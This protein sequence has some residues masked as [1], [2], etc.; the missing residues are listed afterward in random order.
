MKIGFK[1]KRHPLS[2][3]QGGNTLIELMA[4]VL[5]VTISV[6]ALYEMIV[7]GNTMLTY[8][9]HKRIALEKAQ[10]HMELMHYYAVQ[11]DSVPRN[12]Q[13]DY[14]E[15]MIDGNF[16]PGSQEK[17]MGSYHITITHSQFTNKGLPYY[18]D[19]SIDYKWK[20]PL[21]QNDKEIVLKSR[22]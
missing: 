4:A 16:D 8:Q 14:Q 2:L 10:E 7:Q 22:F 20:E 15:V 12:F 5:I 11:D 18:S 1:D 6:L 9:K 3:S 13:G 17:I 21:D 19:V